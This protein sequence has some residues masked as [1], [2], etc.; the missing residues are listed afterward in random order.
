MKAMYAHTHTHGIKV[1]QEQQYNSIEHESTGT[2]AK[3]AMIHHDVDHDVDL[4]L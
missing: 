4:S 2:G 1:N 3:I